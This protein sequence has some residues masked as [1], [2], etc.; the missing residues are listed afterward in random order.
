[1]DFSVRATG[2]SKSYRLYEKPLDRLI[3]AVTLRPRHRDFPALQDISLDVRVG[4]AV[5]IV[6]RNGAGK[7]T[8]LELVCGVTQPTAG[9]VL[10]AGRIASILELGTGFHP[11]FTGRNNAELNAAILGLS[12]S[13]IR[14][15]LPR[16]YEFSEL[17]SFLDRPVKTYSSGMYMRLAF[18]VAVNVDPEILVID[19]ALAVG[20][21]HFQRKCYEKIRDFQKSGRTI[22]FCSHALGAVAALCERTLWL[23]QGRVRMFG[24]TAEVI[25]AYE[26][27]L[28]GQQLAEADAA[29]EE[30]KR[31]PIRI[32]DVD[33]LDREGVTRE[34]F[35]TGEE[36]TLRMEIESAT[37][38]QPIHLL[39]GFQRASDQMQCFALA[40]PWD[41]I[42][43]WSGRSHYHARVD[44]PSLPLAPGDYTITFF[45]GDESAMHVF[46]FKEASFTVEGESL[47]GALFELQHEW[48]IAQ[49]EPSGTS[50]PSRNLR[51]NR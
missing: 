28:M 31:T 27:F 8:L 47:E 18:S 21:G 13:E 33:L 17:G 36:M 42:G 14:E 2:L 49:D 16:I 50:A 43:P 51:Q 46:D 32:V 44:I 20:D 15:R 25:Q 22:L 11:E 37:P 12:P 34:S 7:S 9:S 6:G 29:S 19:E 45:V 5:G 10:T 3:E 1:M 38:E 4:E 23:D 35:T 26:H 41:G 48:V 39:A 30:A 24:S 40:T